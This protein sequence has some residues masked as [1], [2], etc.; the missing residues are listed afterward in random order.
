MTKEGIRNQGTGYPGVGCL[1]ARVLVVDDDEHF[2]ALVHAVLEPRG[3]EVSD[4]RDGRQG[5]ECLHSSPFDAAIIDIVMPGQDGIET[6][7]Q[8]RSRHSDVKLVA[9]S[10]AEAS[11]LYLHI[12]KHMGADAVL[13]KSRIGSL[14]ELLEGLLSH[15]A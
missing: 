6:L 10:G 7:R 14:G 2:R 13:H 4:A 8:V 15:D 11:T 3:I 12:S 9:V 1:G 5:V